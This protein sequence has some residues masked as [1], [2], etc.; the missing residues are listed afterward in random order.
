MGLAGV[1]GELLNLVTSWKKSYAAA[2]KSKRTGWRAGV[3]GNGRGLTGA[4][5]RPTRWA[6]SNSL[7]QMTLRFGTYRLFGAVNWNCLD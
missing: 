7:R 2:G 3:I 6:V 4:S 1:G 5:P